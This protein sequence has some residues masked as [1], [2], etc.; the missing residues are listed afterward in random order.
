VDHRGARRCVHTPEF[1]AH[2]K[3][4]PQFKEARALLKKLA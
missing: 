1:K 2:E 3:L 4:F